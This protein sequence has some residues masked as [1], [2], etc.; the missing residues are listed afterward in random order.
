MASRSGGIAI[1]NVARRAPS[2]RLGALVAVVVL[3]WGCGSSDEPAEQADATV[4]QA[5]GT[6]TDTQP[7]EV[8]ITP[9]DAAPTATTPAGESVIRVSGGST[10]PWEIAG[11]CEWTPDNT[12]AASQLWAVTDVEDDREEDLTI[13]E[14]WPVVVEDDTETVLVGSIVEPG[15]NVLVV[16]DAES[17]FDGETVTVAADVYNVGNLGS[18]DPPDFNV[19]VTCGP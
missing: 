4:D 6:E 1:I 17:T 11:T 2:R 15:G 14:A 12:S 8:A 10:D 7:T 18:A 3:C 5:A 9:E 19:T 16:T 13:L